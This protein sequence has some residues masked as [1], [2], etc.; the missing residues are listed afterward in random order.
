M[1]IN[2]VVHSLD[3]T[4]MGGVIKVVTDLANALVEY[5]I[6]VCIYSIGRVDNIC[7]KTQPQVNVISLDLEKHSTN[8][9][10]GYKKINWFVESFKVFKKVLKEK[11]GEIWL[12]TSPPLNLLFSFLKIQSH[13]IE[14]IGCDHTSTIFS[15]G[16]IIDRLKYILLKKIDVMVALTDQDK[17][18]YSKN[19]INSVVIPNFIDIESIKIQNNNRLYVIYVGRFSDEKQPIEALEIF[20]KSELWKFG[21]IFKMF[22]CGKLESDIYDYISQHK[23]NDFVEV[24][25]NENDPDKIYKDALCLLMTS[26]VEGF[27]MVLLEAIGRKIPCF[28]YDCKYGPRNIILGGVNGSLITQG[29]KA[30]FVEELNMSNILALIDLIS[31]D[32]KIKQFDKPIVVKK[33]L[34]ILSACKEGK[35]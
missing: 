16:V 23:L 12:P 30:A 34:K 25:T 2:F 29:D 14:V 7:F 21:K 33:W 9:Y 35:Q 1:K 32:S 10:L 11:K 20:H 24:I 13:K 31:I 4:N 27:P 5:N 22:G 15:K 28:S 8:Q 26:Q 17:N 3:K 18:F 19:G 6:S